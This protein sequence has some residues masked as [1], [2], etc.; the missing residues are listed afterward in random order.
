LL[1]H[2]F[3]KQD[4]LN[5]P[6]NQENYILKNFRNKY[7][8]TL[9]ILLAMTGDVSGIDY[10]ESTTPQESCNYNSYNNCNNYN[11][12]GCG[13]ITLFGDALFWRPEL[14]G[15]ESAFGDTS[16]ATTIDGGITTRAV[17]ETDRKPHTRWNG[18][19][20]FGANL[21][22]NCTELELYWT[23][24]NGSSE[25]NQDPQFG[26]WRLKYN[27]IDLTVGRYF[28]LD[29]FS[30]KPF[31]G[32]RA[33]CIRQRL[34][35]HLETFVTSDIAPSSIVFT[36]M[37]D[38][39]HFRGIGP[40]LGLAVDW[41]LGCNMR[42]FGS[43]AVVSYYGDC[44]GS[45]FDVDTFTATTSICNGHRRCCF[46]NIGTDAAIGIRGDY[47]SCNCFCGCDLN[48]MFRLGLEQHRIYD[49]SDLG[50]DGNLSL[51]GGFAGIG[52]SLDY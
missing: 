43:F 20:R 19:Y 15:L 49:F 9:G 36:D 40:Q 8:A 39:E 41:Y 2:D 11:D 6:I 51:D 38:R 3:N 30:V 34:R 28:C 10:N 44:R 14:C 26:H 31:I 50:S 23:H 42:L 21:L 27:T 25:F 37:D 29:C 24:F 17:N 12:C 4:Y 13:A 7:I 35:S 48:L 46:N 47:T 1:L 16:I 33:A 32:L 18:G 22:S 52:I 5:K 45:N